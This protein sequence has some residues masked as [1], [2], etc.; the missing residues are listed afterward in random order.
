MKDLFTDAF[1]VEHLHLT[2][3]TPVRFDMQHVRICA[4]VPCGKPS[5]IFSDVQGKLLSEYLTRN[6]TMTFLFEV[7]GDSMVD[8][9]ISAGDVVVVDCKL[10]AEHGN[11]VLAEVN[12][13]ITLKRLQML[14][15]HR[16]KMMEMTLI[17]DNPKHPPVK[18]S[19][20]DDVHIFGVAIRK[21]RIEELL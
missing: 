7:T 19:D 15:N 5:P 20:F 11:I 14:P 9:G 12:G 6:P 8:A 10:K 16:T 18:L 21:M 3:I 2:D 1:D 13:E 4:T 17:P